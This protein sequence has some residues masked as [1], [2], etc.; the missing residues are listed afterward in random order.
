[1]IRKLFAVSAAA[2]ML[3]A[4]S[5]S[6]STAATAPAIAA[7][8][9]IAT[10]ASP[11]SYKVAKKERRAHDR[12]RRNRRKRNSRRNLGIGLG[13]AAGAIAIGAAA[14]AARER[15]EYRTCRRIERRCARR[16]GWETRRWYRCVEN[17][18]C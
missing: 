11:G 14:A 9:S 3:A 1:M 4:G 17:R 10:H 16:Y 5:L 8:P 2:L 7:Q 13:L 12:I 6:V 15:E 18:D